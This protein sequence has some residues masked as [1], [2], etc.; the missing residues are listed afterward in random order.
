MIVNN[1]EEQDETISYRSDNYRIT[2][3]IEGIN[4]TMEVELP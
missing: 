3:I 2:K 4:A 1:S